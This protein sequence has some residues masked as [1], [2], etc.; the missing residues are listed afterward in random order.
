MT[1]LEWVLIA[2]GFTVTALVVVGMILLTPRGEVEL[3]H[4]ESHNGQG[5]ELSRA[6]L[7]IPTG[8]RR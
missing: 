6:E 8:S 5:M 2:I 4:S 3:D 1:G 7:R